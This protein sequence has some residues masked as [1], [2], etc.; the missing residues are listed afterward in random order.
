MKRHLRARV[1]GSLPLPFVEN[2]DTDLAA[3]GFVPML[4]NRMGL[5]SGLKGSFRPPYRPS[6]AMVTAA[7]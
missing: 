6:T 3:V 4:G 1:L 7:S 2:R 5:R